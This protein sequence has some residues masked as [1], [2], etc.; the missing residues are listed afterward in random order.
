MS[1]LALAAPLAALSGCFMEINGGY[2]FSAKSSPPTGVAAT[3]PISGNGYVVGYEVGVAYDYERKT[4]A[5]FGYGAEGLVALK[6]ESGESASSTAGGLG[7]R[8]DQTVANLGD[9]EKLRATVAFLIGAKRRMNIGA[10]AIDSSSYYDVFG[11]LTYATYG[12]KNDSVMIT[13]GPRFVRSKG[14]YGSVSGLGGGLS[15]TY[16]FLPWK[17]VPAK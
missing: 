3:D 5:A 9:S 13:V 2:V 12:K 17:M 15:L 10:T 4:R 11:G 6:T 7:G 16:S 8:V 1:I 14:D